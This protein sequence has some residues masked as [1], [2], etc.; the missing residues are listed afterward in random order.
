MQN[1]HVKISIG[2]PVYNGEKF[3]KSSLDSILKQTYPYFEL[4]I[5]DNASYDR[6]KDICLEYVRKDN[7]IK[8][9]RNKEN[10]GAAE[11]YNNV[12]KMSSSKYFKWAAAD[13][14]IAPVFLEQCLA[15]LEENTDV[16][17]C[18]AKTKIINAEDKVIKEYNDN[19]HLDESDPGKRYLQLLQ[20]VGE[21]NAVFGLIRSDILAETSLIGNYIASD[22]V[23]LAELSLRG[24]FY[25]IPEFLFFRREHPQAS[26]WDKSQKKQLDFFDPRNSNRITLQRL[27]KLHGYFCAVK[28]SGLSFKEKMPL[29]MYL[30]KKFY[31]GKGKYSREI[32]NAAK[33]YFIRKK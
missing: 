14:L 5:S 15:T 9:I 33:S 12:F 17:V 8:Y 27:R 11:N 20:T 6:T 26:S 21:C 2:M 16:V 19:L 18:Y 22:V 10:L 24:K 23:L 1:T 13:D 25:E 30:L 32:I 28:N 29:Y 4:I 31:G 3:I 7:R